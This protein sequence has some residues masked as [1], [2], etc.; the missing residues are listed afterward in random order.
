MVPAPFSWLA[1]KIS[2]F[3]EAQRLLA[4]FGNGAEVDR[5]G[6][7]ASPARHKRIRLG[8]EGNGVFI[9]VRSIN[10]LCGRGGKIGHQGR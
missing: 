3:G 1:V 7:E 8:A 9:V 6:F 2:Q 4:K 10:L 5:G